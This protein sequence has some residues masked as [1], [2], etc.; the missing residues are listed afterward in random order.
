M[1]RLIAKYQ[2]EEDALDE[3]NELIRKF[4]SAVEQEEPQTEYKAYRLGDSYE[5]IHLMTFRDEAAQKQHQN[6]AYTKKFAEALYHHCVEEPKFT[7]V[8]VIE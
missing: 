2:I 7:P 1:V 3:V 8:T 6:A 4:V 5:F